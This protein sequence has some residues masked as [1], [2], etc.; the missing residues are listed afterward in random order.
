MRDEG[1]VG[2]FAESLPDDGPSVLE[3]LLLS[4]TS[5]KLG[6]ALEQLPANYNAVIGLRVND[7]LSFREI[8]DSLKAPLNT[9]KSQYRRGISLLKKIFSE[10]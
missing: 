8:A 10:V 6:L 5:G 1:C 3:K 7:D 4:E 2:D 9:V